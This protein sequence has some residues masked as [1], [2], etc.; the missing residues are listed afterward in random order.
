MKSSK[1]YDDDDDELYGDLDS[2]GGDVFGG[3]GCS[4]KQ[5]EDSDSSDSLFGKPYDENDGTCG[6]C[7]GGGEDNE[8]DEHKLAS[9]FDLQLQFPPPPTHGPG[10]EQRLD[11]QLEPITCPVKQ[12][13]VSQFVKETEHCRIFDTKTEYDLRKRECLTLGRMLIGSWCGILGGSANKIKWYCHPVRNFLMWLRIDENGDATLWTCHEGKWKR[14]VHKELLPGL[15]YG[16]Y[17]QLWQDEEFKKKHTNTIGSPR[18]NKQVF[19]TVIASLF[20]IG[21]LG[22]GEMNKCTEEFWNSP[23]RTSLLE[24]YSVKDGQKTKKTTSAEVQQQHSELPTVHL[25]SGAIASGA[26]ASGAVGM[27]FGAVHFHNHNSS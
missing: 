21:P 17:Q 26:V 5:D 13:A 15:L 19:K 22:N 7:G 6:G 2:L 3:F 18:N 16:L 8:F 12:S 24:K 20:S 23:E 14:N 11:A 1:A 27:V 4:V 10:Q 9:V 25:A